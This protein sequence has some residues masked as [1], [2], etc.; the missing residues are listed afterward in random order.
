MK[1]NGLKIAALL[2]CLALL[3]TGCG[4]GGDNEPTTTAPTT[5]TTTLPPTTLAPTTTDKSEARDGL[6]VNC[7]DGKT[8][9][10]EL[11][12]RLSGVCRTHDGELSVYYKDLVT[13]YSVEYRADEIYQTASV[14]KAPYVKYLMES[15][16]D[17]TK[18][19]KMT[20]KQGGSKY[21]DNQPLGT[22]FTVGELMEYAIRYS[23][24]T[25]YYMLNQEFGFKGF[26]EYAES[27]GV[28]SNAMRACVLQFPKPRFGYLS[29]RDAG[30][31]F[32]D[33]ARFIEKGSD[34][35]KKL[36][37]WLTST[38]AAGQFTAALGETYA[39]AHKYGEQGSQAYHDAA[40]V[41]AP[42][43]Y[44]LVITSTLE[45]YT[46]A[47]N[48]VFKDVALYVDAIQTQLHQG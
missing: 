24:N 16:V 41:Y 38:T 23:D 17:Q 19:L 30:L 1:K 32:E 18:K 29:A 37:T 39:V 33:I 22:E 25:A 48:K 3:C 20:K 26:N 43:P 45:P 2:V 40:I 46:D 7:P 8:I 28:S 11:L 35:A 6:L 44:V 9:D 4:G 21:I 10:A 31:Y 47:S 27:I 5:T 42:H 14:I 15:G 13:G 36:K 34:D 12:A